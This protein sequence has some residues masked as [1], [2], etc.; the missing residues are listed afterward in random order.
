MSDLRRG[1]ADS[2]GGSVR[3]DSASSRGSKSKRTDADDGASIIGNLASSAADT[4]SA[5]RIHLSEK[6]SQLRDGRA[7]EKQ[8]REEVAKQTRILDAVNAEIGGGVQGAV[9][10]REQKL[11]AL[12][13]L[14][15]W[16]INGQPAIDIGASPT[17]LQRLEIMRF[18][19]NL[20][21]PTCRDL[22]ADFSESLVINVE[23]PNIR[24]QASLA[25]TGVGLPE[26]AGE[27]VREHLKSLR[28]HEEEA[29]WIT[30]QYIRD[31]IWENFNVF[32]SMRTITTLIG[33]WDIS[34][35]V[36]TRPITGAISDTREELLRRF[37]I[38]VDYHL[39]NGHAL[40]NQDESYANQRLQH[41][42][43]LA[44]T[45]HHFS[46][47][48]PTSG[49]GLGQRVCFVNL[50]FKDGMLGGDFDVPAVGDI[51]TKHA[52]GL[53]I[54]MAKADGHE[55][56]YHGNFTAEIMKSWYENRLQPALE[57]YFPNCVGPDATES[58]AMIYDNAAYHVGSTPDA[59]HFH[60]DHLNRADLIARMK[61]QGCNF[62]T[63]NHVWYEGEVRKSLYFDYL[64]QDEGEGCIPKSGRKGKRAYIEEVK[65]ACTRW[66]ADNKQSVL[67]NDLERML[68]KLGNFHAVW[69]GPNLPECAWIEM[70]WSQV[71]GFARWR[72]TGK[73]TV[74]ALA[75]DVLDG[76][77][78]DKLA[79][80]GLSNTRGGNFKLDENHECKSAEALYNHCL[81]SPDGGFQNVISRVS[82]LKE[83]PNQVMGQLVVDEVIRADALKYRNRASLR[84]RVKEVIAAKNN[85][86][87]A[88]DAIA[89]LDDDEEG[90]DEDEEE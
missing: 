74:A 82:G 54:F 63:V 53:M 23:K 55:G 90:E 26:H 60:P 65:G 89:A 40:G 88:A 70:G 3:S 38:I 7:A 36:L 41:S 66:L 45:G 52:N 19:S 17:P 62:V 78:T 81:F 79:R 83:T 87:D 71:K 85:Q 46:K 1:R 29:F 59:N 10:T 5:K 35:D 57:L 33:Q 80:E 11:V 34:Y 22:L 73:R 39:A 61:E 27:W 44:P 69:N 16:D 86:H 4:A 64:M 31:L 2:R 49:G 84:M 75:Q 6:L 43:S 13:A 14:K 58:C 24:G 51:E 30:R 77:F 15:V 21:I 67:D 12:A 48:A 50:I 18:L 68:R 76:M 42:R 8:R 9:I 32:Y 28:D 72:W 37:V 47:F 20:S 25:F 56:D